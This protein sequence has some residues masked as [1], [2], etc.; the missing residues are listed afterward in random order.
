M[1]NF[2]SDSLISISTVHNEALI[3]MTQIS[4]I[5]QDPMLD[6]GETASDHD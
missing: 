1:N 3:N 4:Q 6:K 2:L 5:E